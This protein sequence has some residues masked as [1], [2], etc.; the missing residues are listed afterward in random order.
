MTA[1]APHR[2]LWLEG[3]ALLRLGEQAGL[4]VEGELRFCPRLARVRMLVPYEGDYAIGI[5]DLV[6]D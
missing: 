6:A 1:F 5:G 3:L 4:H 2:F